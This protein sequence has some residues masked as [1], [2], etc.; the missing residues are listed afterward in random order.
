MGA[1]NPHRRDDDVGPVRASQIHPGER[2]ELSGGRRVSCAPGGGSHSNSNTLGA[3][4][5]TWDPLVK[6]SGVDAGYSPTPTVL[7]APDVAVGNVP[8]A[9][10][11]IEGAPSLAIEYADVGQ[12]EGA[13]EQKIRDLLAAGTKFLWVVR[14]AG[15]RRVEVYEPHAPMRT[16][17]PGDH[18]AAPGVLKNAVLVEALYDR[19]EAERATLTNLI[20][21]RGYES[22]EDALAKGREQ[23]RKEG[24]S[25]LRAT[26]RRIFAYRNIAL[27][28]DDSA[29]IDACHD[30][31]TLERWSAE[32]LSASSAEDAL[33]EDHHQRTA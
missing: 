27:S 30:P 4:V 16:A 8:N 5:V 21:R 3:S 25:S 17:L 2:Y 31:A 28:P 12:D 26:L 29:R 32:A 7:R 11:W 6:E 15:P 1:H 13:L 14:L 33:R 20:Q 10:G 23:G 19:D 22:L 18:L 9:P 24:L